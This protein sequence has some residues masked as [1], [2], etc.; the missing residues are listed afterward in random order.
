MEA[1]PQEES[2][3]ILNKE[4]FKD[5]LRLRYDLPLSSLTSLLVVFVSIGSLWSV[6]HALSCNKGGFI[7]LHSP[8][9]PQVAHR[10][11]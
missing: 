10:S 11:S 8:Y 6:E 9:Y 4:V 2:D 3:F 1:I 7:N 5:V